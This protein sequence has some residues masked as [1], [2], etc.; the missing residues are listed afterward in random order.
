MAQVTKV[1]S[2]FLDGFGALGAIFEP[3]ARPGSHDNLIEQPVDPVD[4]SSDALGRERARVAT[5]AGFFS[6]FSS[7]TGGLSRLRC[8]G[9][10][11]R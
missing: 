4:P 3:V 1:A 8:E 11:R 6:S 7:C 10:P 5:G 9:L 2:A